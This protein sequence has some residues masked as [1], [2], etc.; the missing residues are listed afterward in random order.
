MVI[1]LFPTFTLFVIF[2]LFSSK[3]KILMIHIVINIT[4]EKEIYQFHEGMRGLWGS[5]KLSF[6]HLLDF[7]IYT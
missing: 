2:L 3:I 5:I 4:R 1:I 7:Y 6:P